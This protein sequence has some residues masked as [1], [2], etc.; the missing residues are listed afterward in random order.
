MPATR[1]AT[2]L[3]TLLS[4]IRAQGGTVSDAEAVIVLR[5]IEQG[6][7]EVRQADGT[8]TAYVALMAR[9]LQVRRSQMAGPREPARSPSPLILP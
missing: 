7:R 2:E 5:A 1:L 9:L 6:A 3:T 4:Q 8:E